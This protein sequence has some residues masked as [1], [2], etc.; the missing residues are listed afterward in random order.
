MLK[1]PIKS[2]SEEE[3]EKKNMHMGKLFRKK[4]RIDKN[5][6]EGI[7]FKVAE[8][9]DELAQSYK[10]V[11]KAYREKGYTDSNPSEMRLTPH[12]THPDTVVFIGLK[13]NKVITTLSLFPDSM[14]GLMLDDL[15]NKELNI[16]RKEKR[17]LAEVG[18]LAT[19]TDYRLDNLTLPLFLMKMVCIYAVDYMKVDNLVIAVNPKH[20][21]FYTGIILFEK[22]GGL[23]ECQHVKDNPAYAFTL[24]LNTLNSTYKTHYKGK[25]KSR[26][27]YHFMFLQNNKEIRLPEGKTP[28]YVWNKK[29]LKYFFEIKTNTFSKMGSGW[30]NYV[31]ERHIRHTRR[32]ITQHNYKNKE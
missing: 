29:K 10:L 8:T 32:N 1:K 7:V 15:Y 25:V 17:K 11:Y 3:K 21:L 31:V 19:H 28:L 26:N 2:I 23:K 12:H 6:V 5:I 30:L 24:N 9:Q 16:L 22:I 13:H 4:L 14:A 27:L 18:A 20:A